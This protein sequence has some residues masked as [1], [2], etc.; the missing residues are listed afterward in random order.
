MSTFGIDTYS[1]D[2]RCWKAQVVGTSKRQKNKFGVPDENCPTVK[3]CID[4]GFR[5]SILIDMTGTRKK[6]G[7]F[8]KN[9]KKYMYNND[10][11]DSSAI[12]MYYFVGDRDKLEVER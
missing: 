9:G 8:Q 10:A 7:I 1:V 3:W 6:K 2:T 4:N 5:S 11:S 12:S